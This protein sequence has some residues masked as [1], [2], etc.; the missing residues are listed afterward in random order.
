M[1]QRLRYAG[2]KHIPSDNADVVR[3]AHDGDEDNLAVHTKDVAKVI[4]N[5]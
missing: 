2:S 3:S 1:S 4:K 5:V